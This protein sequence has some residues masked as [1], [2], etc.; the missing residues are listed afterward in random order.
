VNEICKECL[1]W[2]KFGPKCSVFWE[3]KNWCTL[4]VMTME[5]WQQQNMMLSSY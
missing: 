5:E 2:K 1:K 3:G 4:K